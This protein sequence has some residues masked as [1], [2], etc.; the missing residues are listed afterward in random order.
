MLLN[1][2]A[3]RSR[4][5]LAAHVPKPGSQPSA[6]ISAPRYVEFSWDMDMRWVDPSVWSEISNLGCVG[7][8]SE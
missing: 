6:R 3:T 5:G 7:S 2:V 4:I 8:N 1:V